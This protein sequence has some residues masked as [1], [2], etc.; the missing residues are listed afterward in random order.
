[1][2]TENSHRSFRC[3]RYI[4]FRF[5]YLGQMGLL[6]Y[7]TYWLLNVVCSFFSVVFVLSVLGPHAASNGS[8]DCGVDPAKAHP[9]TEDGYSRSQICTHRYLTQ[10]HRVASTIP[11]PILH[12]ASAVTLSVKKQWLPVTKRHSPL[13]PGLLANVYQPQRA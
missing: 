13:V 9:S 10:P 6:Y 1:M 11:L 2:W 7:S 5:K 8:R 12:A 4:C 3:W